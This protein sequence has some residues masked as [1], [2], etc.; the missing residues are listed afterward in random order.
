MKKNYE[1]WFDFIHRNFKPGTSTDIAIHIEKEARKQGFMPDNKN[2]R[3]KVRQILPIAT[4]NGPSTRKVIWNAFWY[5]SSKKWYYLPY[6]LILSQETLSL[7]SLKEVNERKDTGATITTTS[8]K[9]KAI[10]HSQ[11]LKIIRDYAVAQGY[12]AEPEKDGIDLLVKKNEKY[13]I[14]EVKAYKNSIYIAVGQVQFYKYSLMK[15]Y[16]LESDKISKLNIV[17]D[18]V[19]DQKFEGFLDM[20]NIN[21]ININNIKEMF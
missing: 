16:S 17:G 7:D 18:F 11:L 8:P 9:D 2:I 19:L 21:Y 4:G 3:A 20:L 14:N 13:I 6:D 5:D 1:G 12:E 15:R 10:K